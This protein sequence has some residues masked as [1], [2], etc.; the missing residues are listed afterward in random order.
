MM[1]MLSVEDHRNLFLASY[2]VINAPALRLSR[3]VGMV[4]SGICLKLKLVRSKRLQ[5][6]TE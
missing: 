1:E 2:R 3:N 6:A 5:V 4:L